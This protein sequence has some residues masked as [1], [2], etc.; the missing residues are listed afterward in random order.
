MRFWNKNRIFFNILLLISLAGFL[1]FPNI[2]SADDF[3]NFDFKDIDQYLE[4]SQE[5]TYKII[6]TLKQVLTTEG[7]SLWSSGYVADEKI[8]AAIVLLNVVRVEVLN[9][10]LVDAPIEVTKKIIK[11]AIEIYQFVTAENIGIIL[12]KLE[13]ESVQMAVDYGLQ[14]LIQEE[15]KVAPGA[16][17]LEYPSNYGGK[18]IL[19][20]EKS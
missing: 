15:L 2:C 14:Y 16:I 12:E 1:V 5:D 18:K 11:G 8:A 3:D 19:K 9:H 20:K 4:L 6:S 7:I 13:K 17:K 10:L